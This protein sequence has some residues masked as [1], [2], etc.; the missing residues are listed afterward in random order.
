MA[1]KTS[2]APKVYTPSVAERLLELNPETEIWWDSSPLLYGKWKQEMLEDAPEADR[3]LLEAQLTRLFNEDDPASSIVSGVTTNPRLSLQAIEGRPDLWIP[4]I[5]KLIE[6][7]PDDDIEV[8]YWKTY[9]EVVRRGSDMMMP[10]WEAT[11]HRRGY[12]SGQVDPRHTLDEELMFNEA[13]EI[14]DQNPNVMVKCPGTAAGIRV[15]R[16]LTAMG[17][18]TNC[19]LAYILPQ[20]VAVMDAVE[21]GLEEAKANNV[22]LFRWSSVI[23]QMATRY[24][25]REE[26]QESAASVG[27]ELSL[28][29]R[30]WA[31]IAIL[32]KAHKVMKSR[33]YNGKMLYC[34]MRRGPVV[35][36]VERMWHVEQIAGGSIVFTCPPSFLKEMWELD[37]NLEFKLTIE[38]EIPGEVME[39]LL[40]VPY[41]AEAYVEEM[42]HDKFATLAPTI[43]T[44]NQFSKATEKTIEFVQERIAAVRK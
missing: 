1:T 10:I 16:R 3:P 22:D 8:L 18:A 11:D 41:F 36:G 14:L 13:L 20:F 7:N 27:L 24:E 4:W 9:L 42:D 12:L 33:N 26:F 17:I 6:D 28:E 35:D 37:Q 25:D 5:D 38:E 15:I 2:I 23:S 30:R 32:R 34:S 19:T 29:E 31:A 21:A 40:K 43:F 39:K 44:T